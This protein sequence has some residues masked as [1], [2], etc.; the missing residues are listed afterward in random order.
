MEATAATATGAGETSFGGLLSNFTPQSSRAE[1]SSGEGEANTQKL[2]AKSP[3]A[4][5]KRPEA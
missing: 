5:S 4:L 3:R 1:E 2:L